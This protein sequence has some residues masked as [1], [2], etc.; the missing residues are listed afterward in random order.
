[1][2][3]TQILWV[4]EIAAKVDLMIYCIEDLMDGIEPTRNPEE[5]A[6][7]NMILKMRFRPIIKQHHSMNWYVE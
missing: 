5:K 7:Y 4:R 3:L 1:M 6:R 2:I